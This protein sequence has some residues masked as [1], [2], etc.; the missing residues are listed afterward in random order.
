M[1]LDCPIRC[2]FPAGST[3]LTA[4]L[5]APPTPDFDGP[6]PMAGCLHHGPLPPPRAGISI[7]MGF[8][9]NL[10]QWKIS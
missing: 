10:F 3:T 6:C 1:R 8:C 5:T 7:S 2:Y 9:V 4:A